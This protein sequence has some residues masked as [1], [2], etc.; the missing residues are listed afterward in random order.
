MLKTNCHCPSNLLIEAWYPTTN[1]A[2]IIYQGK[3]IEMTSAVS[4]SGVRCVGG[5]WQWWT[6][7]MSDGMLSP[8]AVDESIA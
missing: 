1:T 3:S 5:G 7:G 4:A 2:R 6:K 8:L